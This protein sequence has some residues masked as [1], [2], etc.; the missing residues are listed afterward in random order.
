ME[1]RNNFDS[2]AMIGWV[3]KDESDQNFALVQIFF[4]KKYKLYVKH[5]KKNHGS[6]EGDSI[7]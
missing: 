1:V 2:D 7:I 6:F 5:S 3:E 4:K